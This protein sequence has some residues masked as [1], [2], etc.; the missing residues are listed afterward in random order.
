MET[1]YPA[2]SFIKRLCAMF[3]DALLAL[4]F[5][6]VVG[7]FGMVVVQS[8]LGVENV[9]AGSIIAK[10]FFVFVLFLFFVFYGWF[11]THG[12][13]TLGMR[14][15]KLKLVQN[16]GAPVTWTQAFFRFCYALISWIPGGAGYL[17]ML[18]DKD[19][20]T[21]HD[22]ASRTHIINIKK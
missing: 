3:Y 22:K 18:I 16:N 19:K 12:G 10:V 1:S 20:R 14:A 9:E 7:F 21:W 13:Q 8:V 15:W 11:W 6:L 2:A 5:V 17:W 4:S